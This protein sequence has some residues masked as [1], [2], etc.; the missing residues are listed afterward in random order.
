VDDGRV[1][2]WDRTVAALPGSVAG[3]GT[4]LVRPEAV[5]LTA[6]PAGAGTVQSVSF[7]GAISRVFVALGHGPAAGP[8]VLAQVGG[9]QTF[10][11]G[12]RVRVSVESA[13]VLV[14]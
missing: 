2:L 9:G 1:R 7:L 11:V 6:D 12:D 14:V 10:A 5:R 13:G 8:L 3:A 4:A